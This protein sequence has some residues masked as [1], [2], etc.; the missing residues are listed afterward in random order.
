MREKGNDYDRLVIR[1]R[2]PDV[3]SENAK[4]RRKISNSLEIEWNPQ[5]DKKLN[6]NK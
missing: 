1:E 2:F 3:K 6:N 5:K 4:N